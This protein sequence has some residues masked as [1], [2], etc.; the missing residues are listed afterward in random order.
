VCTL[1]FRLFSELAVPPARTGVQVFIFTGA[2]RKAIFVEIKFSQHAKRRAKLYGISQS[3]IIDI[4]TRMN[5]PQGRHEITKDVVGFKYPLKI[6][7]SV[8]K[9]ATIVI[10]SYPL[11]K[12]S[13]K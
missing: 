12:R 5:L 13:K 8:E 11:K 4:L 3:T 1:V 2:F 10:T 9:N 7:V 6:V